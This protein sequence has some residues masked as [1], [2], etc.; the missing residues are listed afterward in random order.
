M[1]PLLVLLVATQVPAVPGEGTLV[2]FCKQGRL[3]AC[4]ELAKINPEKYAEVQAEL[5]KAALSQE[6]LKVA[7]EA[8]RAEE[9]AEANESSESETS[10]E[11]PNCKGQN[12]PIISRPIAEQLEQHETL[13]GLYTPRDERFKTRAKD[14]KSHCGYQDWHRKV[15]KEIIEWLVKERRATPEQF[16]KFLRELYQRKE[17]LE[18]FPNGF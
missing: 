9:N 6:A 3:T 2:S 1:L 18:R 13:R 10:D 8:A 16:M 4:E 11:P 14:E 5:A 12:H 17:M 7:E 15:D